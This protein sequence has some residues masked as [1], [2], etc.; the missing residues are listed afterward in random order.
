M[1]GERISLE[2]GFQKPHPSRTF[3]GQET[4]D[5][6]QF[7]IIDPSERVN[8]WLIMRTPVFSEVAGAVDLKFP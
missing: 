1:K 7:N 5:W 2:V 6:I 8:A 4:L 3:D